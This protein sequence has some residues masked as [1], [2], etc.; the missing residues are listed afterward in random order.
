MSTIS[1]QVDLSQ[2]IDGFDRDPK[3]PLSRA[4]GA[5]LGKGR[6]HLS[7]TLCYLNSDDDRN[8]PPTD[9]RWLG[10]FLH[11]AGDRILFFPGLAVPIDWVETARGSAAATRHSLQLDHIAAEPARQRWHFTGID[12]AIHVAAG[13]TPEHLDSGSYFWFGISLPGAESFRPAYKQTLI[14]Y[15]APQVDL[16]R[17][18]KELARLQS[19]AAFASVN[20]D[21]PLRLSSEESVFLHIGVLFTKK[22]GP[23]YRGMEWLAPGGSPYV[24]PPLPQEVPETRIRYHRIHLST[25]WDISIGTIVLPGKLSVAAAFTG[26]ETL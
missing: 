4:Y 1:L 9:L 6:T 5:L 23:V 11:S 14:E 13:R 22:N 7:H 10:V 12:S 26:A 2:G 20:C 3:N 17:R 24:S 8:S 19:A 25:E 16:A 18:S 21:T 15:S